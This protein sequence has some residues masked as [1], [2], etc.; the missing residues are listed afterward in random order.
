MNPTNDDDTARDANCR[1]KLQR[2][3]EDEQNHDAFLVGTDGKHIGCI[4][5]VLSVSCLVMDKLFNGSFR[6]GQTRKAHT[7]YKSDVLSTLVTYVHTGELREFGA[8]KRKISH[9]D[10]IKLN[11]E[12]F[13]NTLS[14]LTAAEYFILPD[15]I[16]KVCKQIP[17]KMEEYPLASFAVFNQF[18][19]SN[20]DDLKNL[21]NMA[22]DIICSVI[23]Q[24]KTSD[25]SDRD[26]VSPI[27]PEAMEK[28]LQDSRLHATEFHLFN[29]L[30]LWCKVGKEGT[31]EERKEKAST[32]VVACINLDKIL[33]ENLDQDVLESGLVTSSLLFK[34]AN[35]GYKKFLEIAKSNS[36]D[37]DYDP[38]VY[39]QYRN[40]WTER[41]RLP[42]ANAALDIPSRIK[43]SGTGTHCDQ[44]FSFE[45]NGKF[46][47]TENG[48]V[49]VTLYSQG[50]N[51]YLEEHFPDEQHWDGGI[52]RGEQTRMIASKTDDANFPLPTDEWFREVESQEYECD[53]D[54]GPPEVDL[55]IEYHY[56]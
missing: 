46:A 38:S 16:Q 7:E 45:D 39:Y 9:D 1:K 48:D 21:T 3:F 12:H 51:W 32:L 18:Y 37:D 24:I 4:R 11:C 13:N 30:L 25:H 31:E 35:K 54:E 42:R 17:A 22:L 14:L 40:P 27:S 49:Q 10:D 28:I 34:A 19:N 20:N 36:Y 53:E 47:G 43:I 55:K 6:E 23:G 29:F 26:V 33:P 44:A 8:N 56:D 5:N 15:L 2:M 50:G 41:N 52:R